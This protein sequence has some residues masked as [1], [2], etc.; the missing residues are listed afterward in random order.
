MNS[1]MPATL[2]DERRRLDEAAPR[3]ARA[4]G[5]VGL[6]GLAVGVVFGFIDGWDVFFR[7]Y[8]LNYAYVLSIALGALFFVIL[9]HLTR[10]GW[11]VVVRRLA[12]FTAG[13][14]PVL[15]VLFLPI[16]IPVFAGMGAVY[17]WASADEAAHDELLQWK[18]SYLNAPFFVVRCAIYFGVW[19]LLANYYL[20]RSVQ[21]DTSGDVKL[22]LGMQRW[23]GVG[24]LLYALTVTFFSIDVIKSLSPHWFSTIFGVYY[25]AGGM[26]GFFGLLGLMMV[27]LQNSGRLT[28][29]ITIEHYHD[30][31]K[32]VFGFIVFWAY[33]AFSQYMLIWY[34][35]IPEET[36]WYQARQGTPWWVGVS[37]LL[38]AGHFVVP[39]LALISRHPKRHRRTVAAGAAWVLVMHWVDLYYLVG[40]AAHHGAGEAAHAAQLHVSDFALLVGLGGMFVFAVVRLMAGRALLPERDPRLAESVAFENV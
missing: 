3:V 32:L 24:T 7:S 29:S 15:A 2:P 22:T 28:S 37:L 33:I 21:Q 12:E 18:R 4:A 25:F 39:F 10:A 8:V 26:V 30:V 6:V 31:G 20:K 16:L 11:S 40:P 36:Y 13:A 23:S 34:A 5:V 27:W 17:P 35:N 19:T 14:M 1:A 38:L 9:Q